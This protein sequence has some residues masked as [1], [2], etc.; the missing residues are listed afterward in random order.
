MIAD[1]ATVFWKEWREIAAWGRL[2]SKLGILILTGVFG[3]FMPLQEGRG[4]IENP[5]YL[6]MWAWMPL[7]LVS[8]TIAD[9]VAGE[10]ER[11]TLE[12]L[13]ASRLADSAILL[14]KMA[15]GATYG[16]ALTWI[17]VLVGMITVNIAF[18]SGSLLVYQPAVL[19]AM[20]IFSLLTAVLAAGVGVLVSLRAAT[21][22]QAQQTL[23]MTMLLFL[24]VPIMSTQFLPAA[25]Q[26]Q[27]SQA[28]EGLDPLQAGLTVG[29]MLLV[30]DVLLILA[31][32]ARFKR[33]RLIL[34]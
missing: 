16:L 28:L 22:R 33:A 1:I 14:G 6:V 7:Y 12:T 30:V 31:A 15:A 5:A 3:I 8:G 29:G 2:R 19:A 18:S 32:L 4:W 26:A 9:A 27:L 20:L 25:S 23:S 34:D 24:L 11:H 13:L 17:N 21:A 10:R